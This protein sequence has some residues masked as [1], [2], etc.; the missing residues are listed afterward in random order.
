MTETVRFHF[1]PRCPWAWQSSK[2]IREVAE[3]RGISVEWRLFSLQLINEEPGEEPAERHKRGAEA[4]RTLVLVRREAGPEAVGDVYRAIG[5]RIH[6]GDEDL[7][8]DVVKDALADSGL[9][10]ELFDRALADDSTE[11]EVR[12]EHEEIVG[13]VGAFGVPTL[14]FDSGMSMFGP[15]IAKPHGPERSAEL[16]DHVKALTEIDGFFELKRSRDRRPGE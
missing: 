12:R 2:W 8:P 11:A 16:F 3:V 5:D 6:E 7:G 15:V 1:D 14:V 10:G 9:D 4:M 13:R